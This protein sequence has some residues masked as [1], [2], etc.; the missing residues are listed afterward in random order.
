MISFI[1]LPKYLGTYLLSS[2]YNICLAAPHGFNRAI[3][4]HGDDDDEL[5]VLFQNLNYLNYI[6]N[7][8]NIGFKI[9]YRNVV[10]LIFVLCNYT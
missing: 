4:K 6:P 7:F 1:F 9:G 2:N 3:M 8:I 10:N 5:N